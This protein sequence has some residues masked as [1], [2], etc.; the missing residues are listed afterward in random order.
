M[1]FYIMYCYL[2]FT[3]D[4]HGILKVT[5]GTRIQTQEAWLSN[6]TL[7]L[8]ATQNPSQC[9]PPALADFVLGWL[10]IWEFFSSFCVVT[11]YALTS[12]CKHSAGCCRA[13]SSERHSLSYLITICPTLCQALCLEVR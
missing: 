3:N 1:K 5:G 9:N 8:N 12:C 11:E 10:N 13:S 4:V 2:H 7:N 6:Q